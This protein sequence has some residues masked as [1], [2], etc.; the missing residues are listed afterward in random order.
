MKVKKIFLS[1]LVLA[2]LSSFA[3]AA[4]TPAG[5]E[6]TNQAFGSYKDANNA[7]SYTMQSNI[8]R[9]FVQQVAG[10]EFS[11]TPGEVYIPLLGTATFPFT[12]TNTGNGI[13]SYD[14][15]LALQNV[16]GFTYQAKIYEDTGQIGVFDGSETEISNSGTINADASKNILL[17]VTNT[18][19]DGM[20]VNGQSVV[21]DLTAS[22]K[23]YQDGS[24]QGDPNLVVQAG[25]GSASATG[26]T[27]TVETPV[28]DV[29]FTANPIAA[30]TGLP[31]V[32][33]VAV[34]N[35]STAHV[36][37]NQNAAY[38]VAV[39]ISSLAG[40][41]DYI[42]TSGGTL[43]GSLVKFAFND[44]AVGATETVTFSVEN[45]TTIPTGT[46][47]VNA[48]VNWVIGSTT[49]LVEKSASYNINRRFKAVITPD[50]DASTK[51]PGE[52]V[53]YSFILT[54][55]SNGID[56]INLTHTT[57]D[58]TDW[59]FYY[60]NGTALG[61]E[62]TDTNS[63][64]VIDAGIMERDTDVS[65][66]A[67]ATVPN[68]VAHEHGRIMELVVTATPTMNAAGDESIS[69][70][71]T[72]TTTLTK[73]FGVIVAP[74]HTTKLA[75]PGD[76]VT[77]SFTITNNGN[78]NDQIV[79]TSYCELISW[80]FSDGTNSYTCGN[81]ATLSMAS[82]EVISFT[83]TGTVPTQD[84]GNQPFADGT[85]I[86][87]SV[88]ATT[89]AGGSSE[90]DISTF[91]TQLTL[92]NL[93]LQKYIWS[94]TEYVQSVTYAK[95]GDELTYQLIL[96]N[97]GSGVASAVEVTDLIPANTTFVPGSVT[98]DYQYS[99]NTTQAGYIA[100]ENHVK[101][102]LLTLEAGAIVTISFR[103][104]IN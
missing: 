4:G 66:I 92:P 98:T 8:V 87:L 57:Q 3:F 102:S 72:F 19:T 67:V 59:K 100:V 27:T 50:G 51:A 89:T 6:I 96:S 52:E 33:T 12:L 41:A 83:V 29:T 58:I 91:T 76:E 11:N 24:H 31:V 93:S 34:T 64:G 1:I 25:V 104:T 77:Y 62:L 5:T 73:T 78:A 28:I 80:S 46:Y 90:S 54:N 10:V 94:G 35:N 48:D 56:V 36:A 43:E 85:E 103:V 60:A 2:M 7:N 95:P 63:D 88:T 23:Y 16:A 22:S 13:D 18:G 82:G 17:V 70:S 14:L 99:A 53:R 65:I 97:D 86:V 20:A 49:Q 61:A 42:A 9:T 45:K 101:L 81:V 75:N 79:V 47:T 30:K 68:V 69:A 37:G 44:L 74:D 15:A 21:L 39:D 84:A 32:F 40:Y 38:E 26:I 71:H 55:K